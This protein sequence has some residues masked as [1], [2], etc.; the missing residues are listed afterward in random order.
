MP[1]TRVTTTITLC[2][3]ALFFA[4]STRA[5]MAPMGKK[6][7]LTTGWHT[8]FSQAEAEAKALGKPLLVHFYA[9]WCGPC[10]QMERSV[11]NQPKVIRCLGSDVVGVKVNADHHP[12]LKSRFGISGFPSDVLVS[13]A[14]KVS[15][16]Y[17]GAT[18]ES[19]FIARLKREGEKYPGKSDTQL[20]KKSERKATKKTSAGSE[21]TD[22]ADAKHLGL[23]GYSPVALATGQIWK[24]GKSEYSAIYRGI[25]YRFTDERELELFLESPADY[26]PK[27]LGCDPVILAESG[28]P[29]QGQ[30]THGVFYG[31]SVFLMATEANRKTFLKN[32]AFYAEKRFAVEA[33]EIEQYVRR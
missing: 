2:T 6:P 14:G 11:L 17:V 28:R 21:K 29:V 22:K 18:S 8:S 9:D 4:A 15:T 19:S 10:Q 23:D 16:R 26:A 27:L 13:P 12:E 31:E 32:P 5:D 30:I 7:A 25:E 24:K 3:L 1:S 33:D 20:A